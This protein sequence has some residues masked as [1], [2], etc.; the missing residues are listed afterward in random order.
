M[1]EGFANVWTPVVLAARLKRHPLA[2]TVAGERLVFFRG[3]DGKIGALVERCPHRGAA[4]SLGRM[5]GDGHL[6][7]PFH[8]WEFDTDGTNV[9]VPFNPDAKRERLFAASVPVRQIG[10]MLWMYTA[11]VAEAPT[12]PAVPDALMGDR[13]RRVYLERRWTCHW[14]RAMENMLD[15][16]HLPFVHRTTIGR[17]IATRMTRTSRM[18]ITWEEQPW[19][20]RQRTLL[21]GS[22]DLA[23]LDFY[24]PNMMQLDIPI[25]GKRFRVHAL[26]IPVDQTNTRLVV[27]GTRDF[28]R[29]RIYDPFFNYTNGVIADQDKAVVESSTP[30]EVPP[31]QLEKS[32]ATD[33]ATLHFRKYYFDELKPSR[34][35]EPRS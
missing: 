4:L 30:P 1:F 13:D 31:V 22:G 12:G 15:S 34:A 6:A 17:T 27:V 23:T 11:P 9:H 2:V 29:W 28:L 26:V 18:E 35:P 24:R 7:C 5:T 25:P 19:G 33:R 10:D 20:G 16:P 3:N 8:G 32:V 21:D 14:T